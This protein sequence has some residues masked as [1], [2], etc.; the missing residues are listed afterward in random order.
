MRCGGGGWVK[1]QV[2]IG[3]VMGGD[4]WLGLGGSVVSLV[5]SMGGLEM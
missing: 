3:M 5:W 1:V 2:G 4:V